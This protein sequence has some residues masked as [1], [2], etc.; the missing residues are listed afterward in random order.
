MNPELQKQLAEM[1]AKLMDAT[2]NAAT[3]TSGQIP[4]LVQ[5]KIAYGRASE[6]AWMVVFVVGVVGF[7]LTAKR[8]VPVWTAA[9]AD[10]RDMCRTSN[11]GYDEAVVNKTVV[12]FMIA[13]GSLLAAVLCLVAFLANINNFMLVWFAPRLYIVEWLRT[14]IQ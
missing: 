7:G 11:R 4:L 5:E 13:C 6:T 3:W 2:Q 12:T 1:L 10:E 9:L 8:R 14:M